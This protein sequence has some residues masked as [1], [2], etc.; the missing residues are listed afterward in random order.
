MAG[1]A[2][3]TPPHAAPDTTKGQ[4]LA[5]VGL[6]LNLLLAVVKLITG[7]LGRS[8]A[9]T[10]DAVES[11][12]DMVG[13]A[14]TWGGLR[15]AAK[16]A[17]EEHPYGHGKAEALAALLVALMIGAAGVGIAVKAIAELVGPTPGHV[18]RG[19]TLW[20]L[21]ATIV[22]KG[23]VFIVMRN[24]ARRSGSQA[25]KVEA[26][27]QVSDAISSLAALVGV[28]AAVQWGIQRADDV[29]ALVAAAIVL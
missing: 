13:S 1:P 19:Y 25:V 17:D 20:V 21:L 12:V 9:L 18:P 29:A 3:I 16:P 22:I 24:A 27:H 2:P 7:L 5:A 11:M 28:A 23:A 8:Y 15:I 4:A 26:F 10:A 6:L 14:V